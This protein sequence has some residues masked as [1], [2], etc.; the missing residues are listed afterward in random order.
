MCRLNV[1]VSAVYTA[2]MRRSVRS[3]KTTPIK[4][5]MKIH[6][7]VEQAGKLYVREKPCFHQCCYSD[8]VFLM[9]CEGWRSVWIYTMD[10]SYVS[11]SVLNLIYLSD[12][13][14]K[15]EKS[16]SDMSYLN[17][18]KWCSRQM[19]SYSIVLLV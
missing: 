19:C 10:F 7:L 4:G 13:L 1:Q 14:L 5:I 2:K 18:F 3:W 9:T 8:G 11:I 17:T 12:L 15:T 6:M 16:E